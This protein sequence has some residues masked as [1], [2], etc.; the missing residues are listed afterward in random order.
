M[1][2]EYNLWARSSTACHPSTT[3]R[4]GDQPLKVTARLTVAR[5]LL[6]SALLLGGCEK[7]GTSS[8][9]TTPTP[10]EPAFTQTFAGT[11]PVGGSR[12]YSF[13]F[14]V[15][16]TVNATLVGI[17]GSGIDPNVIVELGIGSPAG[18]TCAAGRT[19]VQASGEAGFVN[20]VS[21]VQ[22]AGTYC[23]IIADVGNLP[24]P[25]TFQVSIQY[26]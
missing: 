17:G 2:N 23:V 12:F 19:P 25:A 1:G 9:P 16:G 6:L 8:T 4:L 3:M 10:A 26:P 7:S 14:A 5:L 22:Q 21:T 20:M 15:D 11:L 18:V 13:S 24:A